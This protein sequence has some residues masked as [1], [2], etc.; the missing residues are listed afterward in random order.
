M[1]KFFVDSS[2][3]E[4]QF[5]CIEDEGDL[6]HLTRVLR[7]RMGEEILI[8][9]GER[10][11]YITELVEMTPASATLKILDKQSMATEPSTKVVLYQ[12]IPKAAKMETVIQKT[13]EMGV[14]KIVPVFMERTV[15]V[16][17]G[18]FS[19]KLTRW[20]KIADEAVKQCKRGVIPTVEAGKSFAEM[21]AHIEKENFDLILCPYENEESRTMKECLRDFAERE[22]CN[23]KRA[24]IIIGPEGGFADKEIQRLT[25]IG[26]KTV[27]LG[28]T[29]LRTETAGLVALAMIM[30]ELEL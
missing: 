2:A 18:N 27:T 8:S 20:Q 23:D 22:G 9:D 12:G 10:W 3:I 24:A 28:K 17:K 25:E 5:I 7:A 29:T 30:Y 21:L 11:E 26:A 14:E 4:G 1:I 16:E 13:V 19:K 6:H 15:V